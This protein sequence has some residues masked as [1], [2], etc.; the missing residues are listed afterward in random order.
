M[1][2]ERALKAHGLTPLA[3]IHNLTVTAR[4]S[5]DH[6]R[7]AGHR[8]AHA[9]WKRAGMTIDD[10]DLYE[11][12]EAFA[13]VPMAWLTAIGADPDRLNVNGGAIAL[14]HPLGASGTK[15]MATLRARAAGARQALR[16]ADDVR[17]RRH[18][19]R[20]HRRAA[21][22]ERLKMNSIL[23]SPRP[24]PRPQQARKVPRRSCRTSW[25]PHLVPPASSRRQAVRGGR[26]TRGPRHLGGQ[27]TARDRCR[28]LECGRSSRERPASPG[29]TQHPC[30]P[31][32]RTS[33][34]AHVRR[35]ATPVHR[36]LPQRAPPPQPVR[37]SSAARVRATAAASGEEGPGARRS[38][39]T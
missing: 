8:D 30:A 20:H 18:R 5:G 1:V 22:R 16:P 38:A 6:A 33:S 26:D 28:R 21:V 29:A 25:P 35:R 24:A 7:G 34:R 32:P 37:A 13:S 17:R 3:R 2:N 9:R 4:R 14:G 27:R 23:R 11:V 39:C 15:L 12:N 10:I 19:Q 36:E 31:R